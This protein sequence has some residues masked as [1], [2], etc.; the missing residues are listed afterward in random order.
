MFSPKSP[1]LKIL[2]VPQDQI[3]AQD[4]II[5][6]DIKARRHSEHSC[7][8]APLFQLMQLW[9]LLQM[10]LPLLLPV[11]LFLLLSVAIAAVVLTFILVL[12]SLLWCCCNVPKVGLAR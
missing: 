11:L 10:F 6:C 9:S 3:I 1:V 2:A 8:C 7:A 4:Q 5:V 12:L